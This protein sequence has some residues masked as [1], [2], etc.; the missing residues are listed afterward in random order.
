MAGPSALNYGSRS[1]QIAV[2]KANQG[3]RDTDEAIGLIWARG[4]NGRHDTGSFDLWLA[5]GEG[6]TVGDPQLVVV[7]MTLSQRGERSHHVARRRLVSQPAV[8]GRRGVA[9]EGHT[10]RGKDLVR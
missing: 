5:R 6:P 10:M 9:V 3:L 7:G 2:E 4:N 1:I 8:G